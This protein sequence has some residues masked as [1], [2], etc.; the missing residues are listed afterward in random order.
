MPVFFLPRKGPFFLFEKKRTPSQSVVPMEGPKIPLPRGHEKPLKLT[1]F[2]VG[3][4]FDPKE[5]GAS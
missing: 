4:S 2:V 5:L 3:M 1:N